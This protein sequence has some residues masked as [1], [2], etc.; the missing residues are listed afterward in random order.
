M[1]FYEF[2][3][4]L[5]RIYLKT[6]RRWQVE[7]AENLPSKGPVILAANHVSYLD[8]V[9]LGCAFDRQVHFLAKEELF[10]IPLLGWIID[11]LGAFPVKRGAGDRGAIRASL[12][13]LHNGG[14]FGIFPEGG[15]NKTS[16]LLLPFKAG[17]A[18]LAAKSG[19]PVLPVALIG[20][21]GFSGKVIVRVGKPISF[22]IEADGR[23]GKEELENFSREI[24]TA[25]TEMLEERP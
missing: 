21:S 15:R 9:A 14:C 20:T 11:H 1:T 24:V 10:R 2:A 6:F 5:C 25:I 19:A 4:G 23:A 8:P 16:Q 3:R 12:E 18:M 13:I 17:A 7:G 22:P